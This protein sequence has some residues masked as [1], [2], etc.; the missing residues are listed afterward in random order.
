MR[1]FNHSKR[2]IKARNAVSGRSLTM[3][4]SQEA[5]HSLRESHAEGC[6]TFEFG[7]WTYRCYFW[8]TKRE[9][10]RERESILQKCCILNAADLVNYA[11]RVLGSPA[12]GGHTYSRSA[13]W[14]KILITR[15]SF[16]RPGRVIKYAWPDRRHDSASRDV[17]GAWD[18]LISHQSTTVLL[19]YGF[20]ITDESFLRSS[21]ANLNDGA[22]SVL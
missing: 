1:V 17:R 12:A 3:N 18:L 21:L 14:T 16:T 10:P 22:T 2:L 8:A 7:S 19:F 13:R 9:R 11:P 4:R 15:N 6:L 5:R 20:V